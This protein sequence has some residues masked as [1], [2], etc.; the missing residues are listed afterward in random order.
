[1]FKLK[2]KRR[3]SHHTH[4]PFKRKQ[5]NM[6]NKSQ[7]TFQEVSLRTVIL[8][9]FPEPEYIEKQNRWRLRVQKNGKRKAFY[10]SKKSIKKAK[11]EVREKAIIWLQELEDEKLQSKLISECLN[12]YIDYLK[13]TLKKS[14][15]KNTVP[16]LHFFL[17][18][19]LSMHIQE[20]EKIHISEK[21][22]ELSKDR[23]Q[24][25]IK[26]YISAI[27]CFMRWCAGKCYISDDKVPKYFDLSTASDEKKEKKSMSREQL[28]KVMTASTD[29]NYIHCLRFLLSTGLRLGEFLALR[30]CDCDYDIGVIYVKGSL[31]VLNERTEPK[32]KQ[33]QRVIPLPAVA[34][35]A[36]K[37]YRT[38]IKDLGV[39]SDEPLAPLFPN[40]KGE[41]IRRGS[42]LKRIQKITNDIIDENFT[43]HELRHTYITHTHKNSNLELDKLKKYYGHS[44]NMNTEAIYVHEL[45]MTEEEKR[46]ELTALENFKNDL[47]SI[48]KTY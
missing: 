34:I 18:P 24:N 12:E 39:L 2:I 37:E 35:K 47:N 36:I 11:E 30:N 42:F 28:K 15:F 14:T 6:K 5:K 3:V 20:L 43:P 45:E 41:V 40:K 33:G 32:T 16:K 17:S 19:F 29:D 13:R 22:N 1:M 25:T 31:N 10:S 4:S 46:A 9:Q 38:V 21:I 44:K 26:L 23:T 8:Y 7:K 48:F 27:V